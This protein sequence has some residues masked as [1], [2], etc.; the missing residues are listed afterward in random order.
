MM[1][2]EYL[3]F[4]IFKNI[5]RISDKKFVNNPKLEIK[6]KIFEPQKKSLENFIYYMGWYGNTPIG[7][8]VLINKTFSKKLIF[9]IISNK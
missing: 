6:N 3:I 5:D 2:T 4:N 9:N 1:N 7:N 8:R